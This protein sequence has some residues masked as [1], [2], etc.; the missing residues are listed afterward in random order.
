MKNSGQFEAGD[1][2]LAKLQEIDR[3]LQ[4][5]DNLVG[6]NPC[7]DNVVVEKSSLQ[8]LFILIMVLSSWGSSRQVWSI[9]RHVIRCSKSRDLLKI[10]AYQMEPW[11]ILS[12]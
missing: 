7:G 1:P 12:C 6:K 3:D 5:F 10:W 2:F 8:S 9:I 11:P 4:K